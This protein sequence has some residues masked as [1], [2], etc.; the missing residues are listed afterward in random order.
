[1]HVVTYRESK[2][3]PSLGMQ[4]PKWSLPIVPLSVEY[5]LNSFQVRSPRSLLFKR[6]SNSLTTSRRKKVKKKNRKFNRQTVPVIR[7]SA[8]LES[9]QQ[10]GN[11]RLGNNRSSDAYSYGYGYCSVAFNR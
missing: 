11:T 6:T 10:Q 9:V 1:M 2:Q 7:I 8:V 5:R 4:R 3:E